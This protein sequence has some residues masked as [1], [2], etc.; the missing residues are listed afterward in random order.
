MTDQRS[1]QKR[2]KPNML[3]WGIATVLTLLAYYALIRFWYPENVIV[4]FMLVLGLYYL[5]RFI[6]DSTLPKKADE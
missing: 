2:G 5:F 3:A 6:V 1:P 4:R